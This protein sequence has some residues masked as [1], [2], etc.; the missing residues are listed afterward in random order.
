MKRPPVLSEAMM[1]DA[2]ARFPELAARAGRAAYQRALQQQGR[3]VK[4]QDGQLVEAW[5]DGTVRVLQSLP[6]ATPV[7]RGLVLTR[8]TSR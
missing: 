4:S 5:A 7:K 2:E 8:R 1:Q 6:P 3:V